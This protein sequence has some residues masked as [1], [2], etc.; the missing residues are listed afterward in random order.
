M[1]CVGVLALQGGFVAHERALGD[2]GFD[3]REV[4]DARELRAVDG[5]VL[6][7]GESTA[8]LR[9]IERQGLAG[10]LEA[11][12]AS[13]RPVLA[14]CAGLIL[15]ARRV[16]PA[17][18]SFGWL[19]VEVDRNAYGRQLDSFEDVADGEERPLVFIRAP[20]I[21]AVGDGVEV[22]ARWRGEPVLVRAGAVTGATFHPELT[23]DRWVQRLAFD[24]LIPA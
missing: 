24:E 21:R 23:R 12:V 16:R 14:T 10:E 8:Q 13:G 18:R 5:L 17:Q 20:R 2:A 9:L 3:A 15:A 19:D 7:G 1:P 22:L 6:P 4:R 11:F